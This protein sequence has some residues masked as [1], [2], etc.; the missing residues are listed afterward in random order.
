M[1]TGEADGRPAGDMTPRRKVRVFFRKISPAQ[2]VRDVLLR[3]T[4]SMQKPRWSGH[5]LVI[6]LRYRWWGTVAERPSGL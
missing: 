6:V 2:P 5:V 1:C 4:L 3:Q